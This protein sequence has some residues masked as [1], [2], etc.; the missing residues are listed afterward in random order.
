M[1]RFFIAMDYQSSP[2]P[3]YESVIAQ[4]PSILAPV[5][6]PR[7]KGATE[8]RNSIRYSQLPPLYDTTK[9]FLIDNKSAD[10]QALNYQND[11]S[12][13]L[14]TVVQNANYTPMEA[15]TQNIQLDDRSRWGGDFR[16]MLHMNIPN[17]TE[18]MFSNSF[19]ALLPATA[20]AAGTVL[21]WE[22]YDLTLPEGNYSE[23]MV[24]DLLNNAVVETYLANGRQHNVKEEDMGLK[25]DTRN[26]RLGFD[27]ETQL[28]MPGNYTNEAFHPDIILSPGCAVDFTNSRL[29]NF[30]GIRKRQPYQEGFIISWDDL[31]GGNIPALLDLN[32]YDPNQPNGNIKALRQDTKQRSYHVGE[33]PAAGPS[34]FM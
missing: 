22:W 26:F 23:V 30:L 32:D 2:P 34:A 18:F 11:H 28:V 8:G 27:P 6:P 12:N 14:T 10:I 4:V 21:T 3:S 16:S 7:Y 33:D 13:F 9:L 20:D 29:N 19:R 5:V 24:I 15:S 17:I 25:F 1:R 31:Q